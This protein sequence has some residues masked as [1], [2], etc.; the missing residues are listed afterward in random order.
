MYGNVLPYFI[1]KAK[2]WSQ[3]QCI[4]GSGLFEI[5]L[6]KQIY[7]GF[8]GPNNDFIWFSE[9]IRFL[10]P[11]PHCLKMAGLKNR[12]IFRQQLPLWNVKFDKIY[13]MTSDVFV[14]TESTKIMYIKRS[15]LFYFKLN[16]WSRQRFTVQYIEHNFHPFLAKTTLRRRNFFC[17]VTIFCLILYCTV[18][19]MFSKCLA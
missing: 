15:V 2:F 1:F 10:D 14:K 9:L 12:A 19:V 17:D 7:R 5:I 11:R 13:I 16:F 6:S 3:H 8:S 18:F 4:S